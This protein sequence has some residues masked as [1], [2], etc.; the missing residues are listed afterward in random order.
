MFHQQQNQLFIHLLLRES[1]NFLVSW[2]PV[3]SLRTLS[4]VRSCQVM[5]V[6][7]P[8]PSDQAACSRRCPFPFMAASWL[9]SLIVPQKPKLWISY[10]S[11]LPGPTHFSSFVVGFCS[12]I[13]IMISNTTPALTCDGSS[14]QRQDSFNTWL[15]A[16]WTPLLQV[17]SSPLSFATASSYAQLRASSSVTT[18]SCLF[19]SFLVPGILQSCLDRCSIDPVPLSAP[20]TSDALSSVIPPAWILWSVIPLLPSIRFPCPSL[21][22]SYAFGIRGC[23]K[24]QDWMRFLRE[25]GP[26]TGLCGRLHAEIQSVCGLFRENEG[27]S[28]P[29]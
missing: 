23:S 14:I 4:P 24:S 22:S 3:P 15:A 2:E 27:E 5:I 21:A 12:W 10:C 11:H 20:H 13:I 29:I 19:S 1:L 17:F 7:L 9:I 26:R 28:H 16:P 8:R 25:W 6:F 18:T